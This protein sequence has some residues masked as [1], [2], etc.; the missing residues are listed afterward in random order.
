MTEAELK[1]TLGRAQLQELEARDELKKSE[2]EVAKLRAAIQP[3]GRAG[4]GGGGD[5]G[6][7]SS[8]GV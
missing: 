1:A 8:D 4:P 7:R 2:G 5:R 6:R 3:R